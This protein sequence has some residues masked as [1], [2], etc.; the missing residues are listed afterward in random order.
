MTLFVY[1]HSG[2]KS[3]SQEDAAKN[4]AAAPLQPLNPLSVFFFLSCFF[5]RS[6]AET[7]QPGAWSGFP[8]K[9]TVSVLS[10]SVYVGRERV[11]SG[12]GEGG[13]PRRVTPP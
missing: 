12:G 2:W 6:R 13:G 10:V 5:L 3:Q 8:S 9:L 11:G 4:R 7:Q 1:V